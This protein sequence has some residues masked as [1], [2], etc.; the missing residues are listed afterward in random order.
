MRVFLV[1]TLALLAAAASAQ[2][3]PAKTTT[4]PATTAATTAA[5]TTA[6]TPTPTAATP[7]P[8]AA[9]PT[10]LADTA[11][12]A[13]TP[14]KKTKAE[15]VSQRLYGCDGEDEFLLKEI[16]EAF[17]TGVG[18]G[19]TWDETVC[20]EG[21]LDVYAEGANGRWPA[22]KRPKKPVA[23]PP[24]PTE[25]ELA[26]RAA[27]RKADDQFYALVMPIFGFGAFAFALAIA[28]VIGVFLRLRKQVVVDVACPGCKAALP[29]VVGEAPQLFCPRCGGACRVD[30]HVTGSGRR[31]L[32]TATAVPL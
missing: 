17:K 26:D 24:V 18:L 32:T 6:P 20:E 30:L 31:K 11:A 13:A 4:P 15:L 23:P 14:E 7:T 27:E 3:A 9:T 25:K 12:P 10:T 29:F 8:T 19:E 16:D 5:T 21:L 22:Y 1:V 2:D 28:A